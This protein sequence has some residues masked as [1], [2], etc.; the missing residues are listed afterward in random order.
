MSEKQ[1]CSQRKKRLYKITNKRCCFDLA[2]SWRRHQ[3]VV[4]GKKLSQKPKIAEHSRSESSRWRKSDWLGEKNRDGKKETER[5][6]RTW[7][8]EHV[9]QRFPSALC[10]TFHDMG[11]I[12]VDCGKTIPTRA[13]NYI[14]FSF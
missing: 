5:A 12:I 2:Q 14:S 10:I 4:A 9:L 8:L 3:V 6:G 1:Y 13:Q 11:N 7:P